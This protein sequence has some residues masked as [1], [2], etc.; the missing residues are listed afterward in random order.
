[1]LSPDEIRKKIKE[2]IK[3]KTEVFREKTQVLRETLFVAEVEAFT[4][5]NKSSIVTSF[6]KLKADVASLGERIDALLPKVDSHL[7]ALTAR[8]QQLEE[9][10]RHKQIRDLQSSACF[11]QLDV[12]NN[13]DYV[14]FL[15]ALREFGFLIVEVKKVSNYLSGFILKD[16]EALHKNIDMQLRYYGDAEVI[17]MKE[18]LITI[19]EISQETIEIFNNRIDILR[20]MMEGIAT[21]SVGAGSVKSGINRRAIEELSNQEQRTQILNWIE[22]WYSYTDCKNETVDVKKNIAIAALNQSLLSL[23]PNQQ[24]QLSNSLKV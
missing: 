1:M 21:Y 5:E 22:P 9:M 7:D 24:V 8:A 3:P 14:K 10:P 13:S 12:P 15:Q 19:T 2:D 4:K 20:E 11:F 18:A 16:V 17:Q 6:N 23:K